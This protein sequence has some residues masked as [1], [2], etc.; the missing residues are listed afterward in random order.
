LHESNNTTKTNRE[1]PLTMMK[2]FT[3]LPLGVATLGRVCEGLSLILKLLP[4]TIKEHAL[5]TL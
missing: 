1:K 2:L 4:N 5:I 3:E